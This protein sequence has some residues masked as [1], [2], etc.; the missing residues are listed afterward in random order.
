MNRKSQ[1]GLTTIGW[2]LVIAI[3]GSIVLTIFKVLP[4]YLEYFQVKSVLESVAEDQS[5]DPKSKRDLWE[6]ISKRFRVN[7]SKSVKRENIVFARE[8]GVTTV[9]VD[10]RVEDNYV[11]QLF[12][13]AHFVYSVEIRR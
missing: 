8:D 5:I 2:I 13:G 3:F 10:Y 9:T 4:F 1:K 12:I 6:A 7:Q 11:A